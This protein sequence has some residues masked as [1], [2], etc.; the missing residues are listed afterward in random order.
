MKTIHNTHE[1]A[2][3]YSAIDPSAHLLIAG[4]RHQ[5]V[6]R[7]KMVLARPC[8][9][10]T[11]VYAGRGIV[12]DQ[13]Q[14]T[15]SKGQWFCLFPDEMI[16]Y[17]ADRLCPWQY[18]WLGL[19]GNDVGNYLHQAGITPTARFIT[20]KNPIQTQRLFE[21]LCQ[22]PAKTQQGY[23]LAGNGAM[24]LLLSHLVDQ[25]STSHA[26]LMRN[27]KHDAVL[28]AC[29]MMQH[30]YT[31]PIN[32]SLVA[33][34]IGMDRSHLS[35]LFKEQIGLTMHAYLWELRLG[36]A[37]NLL[38]SHP[39]LTVQKIALAVGYEEYRSFSRKF[40]Q[41]TGQTPSAYAVK[42]QQG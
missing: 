34:Q 25:T 33:Q 38:R 35:V 31:H 42:F 20:D 5:P 40:K 41:A 29:T 15:V 4:H 8:F 11:Y 37:Q 39:Q 2:S 9:L 19:N 32:A 16:F 22:N 21:N 13:V 10:L 30:Q 17:E 27:D 24:M 1:S 18:Y 12:T 26:T 14:T 7:E 23:Q 3:Y 36:H 28:R 6:W